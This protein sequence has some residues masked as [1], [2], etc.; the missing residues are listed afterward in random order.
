MQL[1]S[2][3]LNVELISYVITVAVA[4]VVDDDYDDDHLLL[5]HYYHDEFHYCQQSIYCI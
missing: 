5:E 1:I 4:D 2:I 3:Y